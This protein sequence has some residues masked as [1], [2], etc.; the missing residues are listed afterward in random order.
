MPFAQYVQHGIPKHCA[1]CVRDT[2]A[3]R[4]LLYRSIHPAPPP[5]APMVVD[6]QPLLPA[7]PLPALIELAPLQYPPDTPVLKDFDDF[8]D[9]EDLMEG[10]GDDDSGALFAY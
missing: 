2:M 9:D 1:Q 6:P 7:A 10:I 3:K 5:A 4:L 8:D